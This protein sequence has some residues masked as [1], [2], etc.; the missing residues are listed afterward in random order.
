MAV[1][2]KPLWNGEPIKA[3]IK[4]GEGMEY[5]V[6]SSSY[7]D[8]TSNRIKDISF[9]LDEG[10][11]N[12]NPLGISTSNS[13]SIL[14]YDTEDKLSP[15]NT[16]SPYYGK[17]VN[18]VEIDLFIS[19]DGSTWEPYGVY[20]ATSWSG[21]YSD[22]THDFISVSADDKLNTIGNYDL[23]DLPAYSN[24]EAG[25]LI[26]SIM[27][28]IG[29]G[30]DEYGIDPAINKSLPYGLTPGVKVRD[31]LNN[32]C[33]LIYARVIIDRTGKIW[34]VP[35][36]EVYSNANELVIDNTGYTGTFLN[37]NNSNIDYNKISVKY[38]EAGEVSR[39]IIFS[40]SSHILSD[41]DNVITDINLRHRVL[42]IE[43][44][45]IMYDATESGANISSINYKGYQNGIQ[46]NVSVENGPI[47]QCEIIGKGIIVSTTDRYISVD[48]DNATV[49]GG[50]TF[51]F[52]TKQM[53]TK[54]YA[55]ELANS[56]KNYLSVVSRNIIMENTVL[57]PKLYVGDKVTISNTGTIYDGVYKVIGLSIQMGEDYNLDATLIKLS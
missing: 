5:T 1:L 20:Y 40:D 14:L 47:N 36:L 55:T 16:N 27:S 52:D 33:Q 56:L 38:L 19:Y 24:V 51:E 46:L 22:N 12:V 31:A 10:N 9:S 26:G 48:V 2:E 3:V 50:R 57:T 42:S 39:E 11:S 23:P 37:K 32:I 8:G 30:E 21:G 35:A 34:F 17:V 49:V 4:F 18:G 45:R 54:T 25:N 29:I 43:Q 28:G 6:Y 7:Y 13:V 53:M 41:G 44:V 15:T